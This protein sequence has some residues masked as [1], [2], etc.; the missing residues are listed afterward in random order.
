MLPN[1][2]IDLPSHATKPVILFSAKNL[3]DDHHFYWKS[4]PHQDWAGLRGSL[5]STVAWMPLIPLTP[6]LGYLEIVKGSHTNGLH[7][8]VPSGPTVEIKKQLKY[9]FSA[10]P[11]ELGDVLFFSTFTIHRSGTNTSDFIRW[12]ANFRYDN[13]REDCFVQRKFPNSFIY[14][15]IEVQEKNLNFPTLKDIRGVFG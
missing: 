6:N 8:H 11:M 7:H 9:K 1:F 2:G 5:D 14:K 10:I 15:R 12:S 4:K 3:A 13:V